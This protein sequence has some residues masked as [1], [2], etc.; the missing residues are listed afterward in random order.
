MNE[1]KVHDVISPLEPLDPK[2]IVLTYRKQ[3]TAIAAVLQEF[4]TIDPDMP[5]QIATTLMVIASNPGITQVEISQ[6]AN[7]GRAAVSRHVA[8]LGPFNPYLKCGFNLINQTV[9]WMDRRR[10]PIY[11]TE[12]G[13]ALVSQ[14]ARLAASK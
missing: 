13:H 5:V 1:Q 11:L 9:D 4:R 7:M 6:E 12:R 3:T 10:K 14:L 8:V 2:S